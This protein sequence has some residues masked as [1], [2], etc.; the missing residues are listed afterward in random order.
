LYHLPYCGKFPYNWDYLVITACYVEN[1]HWMFKD[2]D[3]FIELCSLQFVQS[4]VGT[5]STVPVHIYYSS[6]H[7]RKVDTASDFMLLQKEVPVRI[8][9]ERRDNILI[10]WIHKSL[11]DFGL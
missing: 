11:Q 3:I 7:T 10:P 8:C 5:S 9:K 2:W 1:F 6:T 4:I